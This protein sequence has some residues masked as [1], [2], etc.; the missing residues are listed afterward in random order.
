VDASAESR[1]KGE[2][3]FCVVGVEDA[4]HSLLPEADLG[5]AVRKYYHER[6]KSQESF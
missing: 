4:A 5:R 3:S 1:L 6:H 2:S